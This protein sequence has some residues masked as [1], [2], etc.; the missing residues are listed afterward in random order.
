MSLLLMHTG[1]QVFTVKLT[2]D[3]ST[4]P[5]PMWQ[6]ILG[7]QGS[8]QPKISPLHSV[9][10]LKSNLEA[11]LQQVNPSKPHCGKTENAADL[12]ARSTF[13]RQRRF[14]FFF[15]FFYK[16]VD[17]WVQEKRGRSK[18]K[19]EHC[20]RG[21]HFGRAFTYFSFYVSAEVKGHH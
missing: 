13:T 16:E 9:C 2:P 11:V 17:C 14:S 1:S 18:E 20:K 10:N 3:Q 7:F 19:E 5:P 8:Y 4:P 12:S 21:L 15:G 6:M